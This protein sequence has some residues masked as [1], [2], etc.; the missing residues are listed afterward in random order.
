MLRPTV[1]ALRPQGKCVRT[2]AAPAV[3]EVRVS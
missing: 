2:G 3:A 1:P